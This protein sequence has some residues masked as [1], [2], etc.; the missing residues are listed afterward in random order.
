MEAHE[1]WRHANSSPTTPTNGR[2]E[3]EVLGGQVPTCG[4]EGHYPVGTARIELGWPKPWIMWHV[5][6]PLPS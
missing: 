5:K 2:Y 6:N 3:L 4:H 1:E